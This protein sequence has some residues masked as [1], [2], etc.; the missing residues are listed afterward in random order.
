MLPKVSAALT[1]F[2]RPLGKGGD[3]NQGGGTA[4]TQASPAS[5]DTKS[6]Q[7][8]H[9]AMLEQNKKRKPKLKLVTTPE[10]APEETKAGAEGEATEKK[11]EETA[12]AKGMGL[13]LSLISLLDQFKKTKG[14]FLKLFAVGAYGQSSGGRRKTKKA[15]KGIMVDREVG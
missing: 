15:R 11:P 10:E 12:P 4:P 6:E 5:A 3:K 8:R 7:Q 13:G 9:E 2:I 14:H 1:K